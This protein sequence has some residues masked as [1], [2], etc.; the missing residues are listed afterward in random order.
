MTTTHIKYNKVVTVI[1]ERNGRGIV[2]TFKRKSDFFN[3]ITCLDS[4]QI[5]VSTNLNQVI[6]KIESF[7]Y[8]VRL[9]TDW[10]EPRLFCNAKSLIQ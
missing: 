7:G 1:Q 6:G 4:F 10:C 5:Q 8:E 2:K 9:D 3:W